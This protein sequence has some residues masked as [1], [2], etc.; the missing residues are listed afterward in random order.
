MSGFKDD[1]ITIL[2]QNNLYHR[3]A[4]GLIRGRSGGSELLEELQKQQFPVVGNYEKPIVLF[5]YIVL[6]RFYENVSYL[7]KAF[8][9]VSV[10]GL[11]I[12]ELDDETEYTNNYACIFGGFSAH[13]VKFGTRAY[14]V[15]HAGVDYG[16]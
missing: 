1:I 2:R 11:I 15:I 8:A 5:D 13:K 12:L 16:D 14:L 7:M 6:N 4:C 9:N 10:G 3:E